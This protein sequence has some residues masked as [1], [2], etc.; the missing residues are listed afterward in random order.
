MKHKKNNLHFTKILLHIYAKLMR[1]ENHETCFFLVKLLV[2]LLYQGNI[3]LIL[4]NKAKIGLFEMHCSIFQIYDR[5][6]D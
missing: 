1:T 3:F 6:K 2:F 4:L 5:I